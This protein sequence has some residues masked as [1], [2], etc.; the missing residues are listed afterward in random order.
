M[1]LLEIVP[2]RWCGAGRGEP[3]SNKRGET[4]AYVHAPRSHDA[5]ARY[6]DLLRE[7][8]E[9]RRRTTPGGTGEKERAK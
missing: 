5:E 6:A 9:A 2:C 1:N 7:A 8:L 4:V 3:C